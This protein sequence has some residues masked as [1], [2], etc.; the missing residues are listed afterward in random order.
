MSEGRAYSVGQIDAASWWILDK[1]VRMF[2]FAGAEK[3]LLVDSGHGSGDIKK[4]VSEL[5]SLPVMLVNTH[6][7]YDHI[8]GNAQFDT[9][10]MHPA[11]FARYKVELVDWNA[12]TG[13]DHKVAPLWEWDVIDIGGRSFEVILIPGHTPGSIALLDS[14]NRILLGGDS[15]LDDKI[16]MI[17]PWRD[18]DAYICSIEKLIRL[19]SSFD[20]VYTPHGNFP[21]SPGILDGILEG[22]MRM[23]NGEIEGVDT[24]FIKGAKMYDIGVAKFLF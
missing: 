20:S 8:G 2:L 16:A 6:G 14:E 7:D 3:A 24:D 9:A 10:Y 12:P 19:R 18:F 4:T 21:L 22:A 17:N 1:D 15:V 5:T 11:E 23:K 13:K